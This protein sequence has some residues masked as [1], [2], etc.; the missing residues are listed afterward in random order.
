MRLSSA[1]IAALLFIAIFGVVLAFHGNRMVLTNDEGIVL[2]S[3]Q[4]MAQGARPYVDFFGYMSPGSYWMQALVFRLFGIS[5]WAGRLIVVADFALQCALLYW[6]VLRLSASRNAA[7]VVLMTFAGFQIADPSFLT[8]QH[9]W[10]SATL[11]LAGLCLLVD[12]RTAFRVGASGILLAAAAWCTPSMAPVGGVAV[13][14]FAISRER[15]GDIAPFLGGVAAVSLAAL[16]ALAV[17]GSVAAFFHQMLW[18][19]HNYS[20]VNIL[21]YGS[22]IGGYRTLLEGTN[23][24]GELIVRIVLVACLAIPAILP[25]AAILLSGFALWRG[26]APEEHRRTIPLLLFATAALV[27]T[28]FPRADMMHLAFIAALPY[29]LVAAA[30]VRMLPARGAAA[31][32]M[33]SILMAAIFASNYFRGWAETAR[34]QSP[35]GVLRV[36]MDQAAN[37]E[38]LMAD[39]HPGEGLFVYPYMPLQY[40]LTQARNPTR[41]SYLAPGMMTSTEEMETLAELQSQPPEWLLYLEL[42]PKEFLRVFPHGSGLN[43]RFDTLEDWMRGNYQVVDDPPVNIAGYRLWRRNSLKENSE[44]IEKIGGDDGARNRE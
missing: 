28:A 14:W 26:T 6:L 32:A 42:T 10:D 29:A 36:P 21:P 39:V 25:P 4:R 18:L 34:V 41:F 12:K 3:A 1:Q 2:E 22:V 16:C 5:L 27:M 15:R 20:S 8:A 44:V 35:A 23:G 19:R 40:F 13:G 38:K 9:R 37:E 43:W 30:L 7:A 17:T 31:L 11:A 33:A 24:I